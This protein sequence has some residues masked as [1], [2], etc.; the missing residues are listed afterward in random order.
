MPKKRWGKDKGTGL[1]LD[2]DAYTVGRFES[3]NEPK[4]H[5]IYV[6]DKRNMPIT[7]AWLPPPDIHTRRGNALL[8][9]HLVPEWPSGDEATGAWSNAAEPTE[10]DL[11][12]P[13]I[14]ILPWKRLLRRLPGMSYAYERPENSI[15]A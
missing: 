2:P 15:P 1:T 3:I 4:A 10:L 12:R 14:A 5:R 8:A 9:E 7:N 6:I 11:A 13:E